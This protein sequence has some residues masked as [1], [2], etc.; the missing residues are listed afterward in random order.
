M[1]VGVDF[2]FARWI[3]ERRG[4]VERQAREG[5]AYAFAGERKFR[6]TL[7]ATR[8]V[9]IALEVTS[10]QWRDKSREELMANTKVSESQYPRVYNAA[11][12]A[13]AA[14]RVKV[15]TIF[16]TSSPTIGI[17]ALGMEDAP[18]LVVN[19]VLAEKLDDTS[20]VA[21]LGH[22]LGHIQNGHVLYSTALHYLQHSAAFFVRWAVQPAIVTLQAWSR[23]AEVT[24]DRAALLAVRNLDQAL[25][26]LSSVAVGAEKIAE[27]DA[28]AFVRDLPDPIVAHKG[29]GKFGE[30]FRSNPYMAKR[31]QALRWFADSAYFASAQ[32]LDATGKASAVDV[33]QKVA[34]LISVF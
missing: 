19:T 28:A 18:V 26:G 21:A 14:L 5:V 6:R 31:V 17:Q 13:G 32:G 27:F 34:D 16:A 30:L 20:L 1:S 24:C 8:P 23:R 11:R 25:I 12:T 9:M 15:P 3:A 2:D 7:A 29:F 10:R 22:A 33:D 4:T